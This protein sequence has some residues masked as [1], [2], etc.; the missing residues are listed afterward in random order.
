MQF[1]KATLNP[2][3]EKISFQG[4]DSM[5]G[6]GRREDLGGMIFFKFRSQNTDILMRNRAVQLKKVPV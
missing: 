2:R 3:D 1:S 6:G 5:E 4:G